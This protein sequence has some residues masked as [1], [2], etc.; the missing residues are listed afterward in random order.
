MAPLAERE[1]PALPGTRSAGSFHR[2]R[3]SPLRAETTLSRWSPPI[4]GTP[5]PPWVASCLITPPPPLKPRKQSPSDL[6]VKSR[7]I[8]GLL[9]RHREAVASFPCHT[10]R[11]TGPYRAVRRVE[12]SAAS[13]SRKPERVEVRIGQRIVERRGVCKPPRSVS[14]AR[15]SG[16][17]RVAHAPCASL[18]KTHRAPSPLLPDHRPQP[19]SDPLVKV[20]EH[21]RRLTPSEITDPPP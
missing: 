7:A 12:R 3:L 21:R 1:R 14:A 6:L 11:R 19:V 17:K 20:V 2:G 9:D 8:I 15:R 18:G 16:G 10:T 5:R 13:Q 4:K